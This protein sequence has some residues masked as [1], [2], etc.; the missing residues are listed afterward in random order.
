MEETITDGP[1]RPQFLTVLC[2]LTYVGVGVG[3]IGSVLAWWGM[4]VMSKMIAENGGDPEGIP[5]LD[6]DKIEQTM[7]MIKYSNVMLI[8]GIVG[9]LICLL[10]ALQMWQQKKMGFYIYVVGEVAP[11]IVSAV[12]LG[13]LAFAGWGII[14]VVFPTTFIVLYAMNLKHL[15]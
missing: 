7:A 4:S 13:S 11:L 10:G 15:S 6:P 5:G 2:I 12:C 8:S 3:I 14:G 9:S 1:K